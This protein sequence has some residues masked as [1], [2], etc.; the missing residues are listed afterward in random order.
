MTQKDK[1]PV[2]EVVDSA[3]KPTGKKTGNT[4]GSGTSKEQR[5]G[6]YV[7]KNGAFYQIKAVRDGPDGSGTVE[8][9][10][11]DFTCRIV[12][13][14]TSDDGLDDATFL[15]IEGRRANGVP[16]PIVD[17]P[18]KNFYSSQ[19]NWANEHW[20][21][22]PFI[23]PGAAKKDNLRACIH[24]YSQQAGDI[25][26]RTVFKFTGWK[27]LDEKWHYLTGSGAITAEGLIGGTEVD[28]GTGHMSRY[29]LPEPLTGELL[30]QAVS[31]AL[32]L[33]DVCPSKPHI[34][35][36][37]FAAVARAPLEK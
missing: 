22:L 9:P 26:R 24:L 7:I 28:L 19:G 3:K 29:Q 10:L 35:I 37:L 36:A 21:T 33:L 12:E 2:L 1:R 8:F 32:A 6:D 23:Y 34:G 30:K 13:E 25:P 14:I 5:F 4:G 15:R 27:K 31:D 18:A 17:V 20:G 11:C 16:L